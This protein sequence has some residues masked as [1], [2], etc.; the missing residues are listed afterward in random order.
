[1][2]EIY[3][4]SEDYIYKCPY[5]GAEIGDYTGDRIKTHTEYC[6]VCFKEFFIVVEDKK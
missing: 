3:L 1:M 4:E 5:C 6:G 2:R